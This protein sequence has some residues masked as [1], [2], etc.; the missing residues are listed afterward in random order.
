MIKEYIATTLSIEVDD[1]ELAQL[2]KRSDTI[3]A[4][5]V[6]RQGLNTILEE[7]NEALAV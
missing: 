2:Y 3:K 4:N 1:F 5:K 6:F 7:I